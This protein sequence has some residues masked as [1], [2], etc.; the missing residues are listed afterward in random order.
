MFFK[1]TLS[2]SSQRV[3]PKFSTVL[4]SSPLLKIS[5]ASC[6]HM[7]LHTRFVLDNLHRSRTISVCKRLAPARKIE[8]SSLDPAIFLTS[9]VLSLP[10]KC[11]LCFPQKIAVYRPGGS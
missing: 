4:A 8:K 7:E 10:L 11:I 1:P 5:E 2:P 6:S 3:K 9:V